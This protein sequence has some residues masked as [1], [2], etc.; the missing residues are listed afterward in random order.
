MGLTILSGKHLMCC[1]IFNGVNYC[2]DT[3]TGNDFI[4]NSCGS[5]N[6]Q[7]EFIENNLEH[8][9]ASFEL[10]TGKGKLYN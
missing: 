3:E 6:N 7:Q 1:V 2:S 4:I 8:V 5:S 10:S 9:K